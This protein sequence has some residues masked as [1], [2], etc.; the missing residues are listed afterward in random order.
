LEHVKESEQHMHHV[1]H[2]R[3]ITLASRETLITI[4]ETLPGALF[5]LD[6]AE[7]IVYANAGAEALISTSSPKLFLGQPLWRS[8]PQLVSASLYRAVQKTKQTRELSEV[9]YVSPLTGAVLH[10]HLSPT[11]EGL[12]LHFHEVRDSA[13]RQERGTQEAHFFVEAL[14]SLHIGIGLLTPDG[15]LLEINEIP[16]DD[17]QIRR[18][19]VI[20][21]PLA[22]TPWWPFSSARQE[23]IRTAIAQAS[24]G[25]TVHFETEIR[26]REGIY[27][28]LEASITPHMDADHHIEYFVFTGIDVTA[29][30]RAEAEIHA[31]IDAIP[32]FVW[33]MRPD[34]SCDYCNQRWCDYTTMTPDQA[35]GDGWIQALHPADR[36]STLAAWQS[37]V[38]TGTF[39]E[40]E[41]R[42]RNGT[43]GSYHWFLARAMPHKDE[44]STILKWFGTCT[45]IDE[46]KLAEQRFKTSEENWQV[47]AETLPHLVW[48]TQPDGNANYFNQRW[49]DY[50]GASPAQSFGFAWGQFLH[51]DDYQRTW[52]V[53]RHA[54]E[55]GEPYEIEYRFKSGQTGDYHWF[56]ARAMPVHD[57]TGQ[58]TTWFGTCTD[59]DEQKLAEQRI[60]ASEENWR[61]LAETVPQFVWT[62]QPDGA[63]DYF[64]QRFYKYVG[65]S[66]DQALGYRW[67]Q[68]LHPDD[69]ERVVALLQKALVTGSSYELAYRIRESQTGTYRWF[70]TRS[71]LVRDEGGQITRWVSTSTDIDEQKRIEEALRQSQEHVQ[72]LLNSTIIG[73]TLTEGDIFVDANETFLRMIGYTREDLHQGRINKA[74]MTPPEYAAVTRRAHEELALCQSIT[75][76]EKEYICKDGSRLPVV[77]GGVIVPSH[78]SQCLYFVLDNSARQELEQR[79]DDFISMASHELRTPLTSLKLQTQ[80]LEKQLAKQGIQGATPALAKI[81]S[82]IRLLTRL[83][84][85]LLDVSKIQAGKLDYLQETVD[86]DGLL[87]EIA[88]TIQQTCLDHTIIVRGAIQVS[89]VGDRDRLGQVFT[90]LLTNAIKYSPG[91]K[92]VEIDLCASP[93]QAMVRV[94]DHGLGIPQAQCDKIFE[95]FYRASSSMQRAIP[96]LGMGL[97]IVAEIIKRMGG[98][99]SVESTVGSGSTFT[100]TFP[101]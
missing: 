92:T 75:P 95:R 26:P 60:K 98:T 52:A 70:L 91:A 94:Q 50:T 64:N 44:A 23:Q 9:E 43:T 61:V 13:H 67:K 79:K 45:D 29:C 33:M 12:I 21:K 42:L 65:S 3:L 78:P 8:V 99:I 66:P 80:L 93:E 56:L 40:V 30:K 10:V 1:K 46:Q 72:A 77:I 87:R 86:L 28:D 89:L 24:T 97:Y 7:T 100:V 27:L 16:L 19:E 37:A 18:E 34:G 6:D 71:L 63:V 69:V 48:T 82:Q 32:Q 22:E 41:Q 85:E 62:T 2:H 51:P 11:V 96:G 57:E 36:K 54:L 53:W 81:E 15:V 55:T 20:G 58:I 88:D 31:L 76:Y 84:E 14:N 90:N 38:Q 4:L 68:F 59:I 5:V 25:E 17:A 101:L 49:Y 73:I 47:L 39:F 83:I 35:Q 74:G